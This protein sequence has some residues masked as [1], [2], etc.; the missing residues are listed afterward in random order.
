MFRV[1]K[2]CLMLTMMVFSCHV[3][4]FAQSDISN[5][6]NA[7]YSDSITVYIFL[8]DE[9]VISQNYMPELN[10]LYSEHASDQIQ[11]KGLFQNSSSRRKA[12]SAYANKYDV[13]FDLKTDHY[14]R[15]T[16][17]LNAKVTPEVVVYD[18]KHEEILYQGRIDNSFVRIGKRRRVITTHE[19]ADALEAIADHEIISIKSTDAVGC[20][21]NFKK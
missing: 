5:T 4:L 1:V 2:S 13:G 3:G 21:I 6:S 9:C 19:L 18:E 10:R 20:F 15:I 8:L 11:F 7:S 17:K 12:I 14:H 16:D